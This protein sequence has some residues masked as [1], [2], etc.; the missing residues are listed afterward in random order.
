[1]Q[2]VASQAITDVQGVVA[3]RSTVLEQ[4][5]IAEIGRTQHQRGVLLCPAVASA[6]QSIVESGGHVMSAPTTATAA[7]GRGSNALR[8][9]TL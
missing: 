7:A 8:G 5:Q 4:L 9:I 6:I 1:M 2:S 3:D